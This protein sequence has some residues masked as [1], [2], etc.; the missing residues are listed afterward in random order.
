M[1]QDLSEEGTDSNG[2]T[3][4]ERGTESQVKLRLLL[5]TERWVLIAV[6]LGVIFVVL[7][8]L[9][10]LAPL[11]LREAVASG[12]PISTL[13]QSL[14]AAI[15][16]GVTLV[17]TIT[18][19]VLSAELGSVGKQY[20]RVTKAAAFDEELEE[21]I[22]PE[23]SP[24]E[25]A[26]FLQTIV[27]AT[28]TN[29]HTAADTVSTG[30]SPVVRD[31]VAEFADGVVENAA[32]VSENLEDAEFGTFDVVSAAL[33]YNYSWKIY[34]VRQIRADHGGDLSAAADGALADLLESFR[35]FAAA[36]EHVKTLYFRWELTNLSREILYVAVPA[37]VVAIGA[38]LVLDSPTAVPG[39][40]LGIDNL[41]LVVAAAAT[42]SVAPFV[43]LVVYIL[44]IV[45]VTERTLATGPRILRTRGG[46][47]E[48]NSE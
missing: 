39:T 5:E 27:E 2:E 6:L 46:T 34:D 32:L 28:G 42:V 18:Q 29:A 17:V 38:T 44:R 13:F 25:P 19:L 45:T 21:V 9:G 36:R 10:E 40:T 48:G 37:L 47:D 1:G 26:A 11:T 20:D 24:A 14:V 30:H 22:G 3:M 43:L 15:I 12:S 41:T 33:D 8:G 4:A 16:T 7:V 23:V 31:R 35:L